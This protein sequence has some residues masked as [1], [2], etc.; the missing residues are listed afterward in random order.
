MHNW[1]MLPEA[2]AELQLC[3]QR[4]D[5]GSGCSV[6]LDEG[7]RKAMLWTTGLFPTA[8]VQVTG[9]Q[10]A[11][12]V[13]LEAK[14]DPRLLLL[15]AFYCAVNSLSREMWWMWADCMDY[16][17][18]TQQT[19]VF[20]LNLFLIWYCWSHILSFKACFQQRSEIFKAIFLSIDGHVH[21]EARVV[22]CVTS[23]R[24]QPPHC[25]CDS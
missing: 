5:W 20:W 14:K 11:A 21:S 25:V 7:S 2:R 15:P 19:N 8:H 10:A 24:S 18:M 9:H 1:I 23:R 4:Y 17:G 6:E 12:E 13:K 22:S 3:R 16:L